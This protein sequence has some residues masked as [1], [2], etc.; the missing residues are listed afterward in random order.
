LSKIPSENDSIIPKSAL[1]RKDCPLGEI[2]QLVAQQLKSL[3]SFSNYHGITPEKVRSF[4]VESYEALV[5]L[6]DTETA[7]KSMWIV[8]RIHTQPESG[9]IVVC[10]PDDESWGVAEATTS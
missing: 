10:H 6:D 2:T 4:L 7:P 1:G 9:H 3:G 5:D 8:L